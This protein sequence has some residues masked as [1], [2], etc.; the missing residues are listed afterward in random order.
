MDEGNEFPMLVVRHVKTVLRSEEKRSIWPMAN[1]S[2]ATS[3]MNALDIGAE[4][5]CL[6]LSFDTEKQLGVIRNHRP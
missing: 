3:G 5:G 4:R 1:I 2:S 6:G